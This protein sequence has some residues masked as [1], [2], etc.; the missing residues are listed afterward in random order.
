MKARPFTVFLLL[1]NVAWLVLP[2]LDSPRALVDQAQPEVTTRAFEHAQV[3]AT[4]RDDPTIFSETIRLPL[5]DHFQLYGTDA[6]PFLPL[7]SANPHINLMEASATPAASFSVPNSAL[8]PSA[9]LSW[10]DNIR[11]NDTITCSA[12]AKTQ[13]SPVIA[14]DQSGV[15]YAVWAYCR[16]EIE[17]DLSIYFSKSTDGGHVWSPSM[18]ISQTNDH[19]QRLPAIA[20]GSSD[21]IYVAWW[22]GN[23]TWVAGG[24]VYLAKSTDGGITWSTT[25]V[26]DTPPDR[27]VG[28]GK[29]ALAVDEG[30]T[31]YMAWEDYRNCING[32]YHC[33]DIYFSKSTDG[34]STFSAN[35]QINTE[36]G[37]EF[38]PSLVA[39]DST[40]YLV[41]EASTSSQ[42]IY[43]T[44]STDGGVTF[45]PAVMVNEPSSA[46]Q[47]APS[48][49]V[50]NTG[51]IHVSWDDSRYGGT[52]QRIYYAKS[53]DGGATFSA[54][55]MVST[56]GV[57]QDY[58]RSRIQVDS[59]GNV[60]I[61]WPTR[62]TAG[63]EDIYYSIST[64]AGATFT[65]TGRVNDDIGTASQLGPDLV[66]DE[67]G[68]AY[69]IWED[70]R[71]DDGSGVNLDVY[72]S[73][74]QPQYA[75]PWTVM[76][77]LDGDNDL[78]N[79]YVAAFNQL[80]N[81]ADNPN[82]SILVAWDRSANGNSAYYEVQ[83]DTDLEETAPAADYTD[84][85]DRWPQHELSMNDPTTLGD[86]VQWARTNYP[87]QHYALI[88]SN[89]GTGLGG[90]AT[91]AG[92]GGDWLTVREWSTALA[93]ATSDGTHKIDVVFADACLMAMIEDAYQIRN[94]TDYYVA[95]E[96]LSWIP[97]R[98]TSGP[99]DD[100]I[101]SIGEAT[102]PRDFA[103]ALV[104]HYWNWLDTDYSSVGYTIS[105]V[106]LAELNDLVSATNALASELNSQMPTYANQISDARA[107]TQKFD[108]NYSRTLT[109]EDVYIDLY[110]FANGIKAHT[111]DPT[112]QNAAD[113]VMDAVQS[114]VIAEVHKDGVLGLG[115][116]VQPLDGSYG[117]SIFFPPNAS[118]FYNSTNYDFAVGATWPSSQ[119][120]LIRT[121]AGEVEWGP[122]LVA[123]FNETQ[124]G[125]P[126]TPEPPS[127]VSPVAPECSIY[128]PLIV[129][130]H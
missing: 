42:D 26:N 116:N 43:F 4:L 128:L 28:F 87:A 66:V 73:Y 3:V 93:T 47:C 6:L 101:S 83:H 72:F 52:S 120:S 130:D 23:S 124:P 16:G 48:M 105:A 59:I 108:S 103:I 121:Q 126:D 61:V 46:R 107:G 80:E 12:S 37:W 78:D 38:S 115:G 127:P 19:Y 7:P 33:S 99:Y 44:E 30:G 9:A 75:R 8:Y 41:W 10:S 71:N 24:D 40:I 25:R 35:E 32:S 68:S 113:S 100:Y 17:S 2:V 15:I 50:D 104:N 54:D 58:A 20:V 114:Y 84:G 1:L 21:T 60:H 109:Q 79:N 91:D 88:I 5:Y 49:A 81:A 112:I 27:Y 95:S 69:A 111:S 110:D 117:V 56:S 36:F 62:Y 86:F 53:T 63:G 119:D 39:K 18:P 22:E 90:L 13:L 11:V 31:I 34:G 67:A 123:Y 14:V 94:Y 122:M 125:G 70:W 102:S 65:T 77:Y 98:S 129:R 45:E 76:F 64:D 74:Q 55:V 92:S 96:N 29:S 97:V 118:S 82:V 106:D 89:H 51:I 57:A 85:V